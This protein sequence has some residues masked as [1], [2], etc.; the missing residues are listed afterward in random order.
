MLGQMKK[1][2]KNIWVIFSEENDGNTLISILPGKTG[3]SKVKD[4]VQQVWNDRY[5]SFDENISFLNRRKS[6][7][8]KAEFAPY[9]NIPFGGRIISGYAGADVYA[10]YAYSVTDNQDS[11]VINYRMPSKFDREELAVTE[12]KELTTEI[13]KQT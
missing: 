11:I 13:K 5:L 2:K 6:L 4:Y 7:P 8:Y 10:I 3:S 1:I 12:W 9:S